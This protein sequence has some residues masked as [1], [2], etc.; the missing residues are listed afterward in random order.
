MSSTEKSP[1]SQIFSLTV[2]VASLGYFVDMFDLLLFPILR[3]PSLTDLGVP[4]GDAQVSAYF[5]LLNFQMVGMLLG[6]IFW[7]VLGDKKGRLST[8]FGSIALYSLANIANAFVHGIPA[9]AAWRFLAGLGLAGELGAAVTLVSEI[10][11]R[12]LRAY[13]TAIIAGVGIFG[14]VAASLVGKYLPWRVAYLVGG[15]LGLLLL[16]TRFSLRESAMF[17]DLGHRDG[18]ARGDFLSLFT[19]RER[20]FRYLR[21]ILIGLPTWFCVAILVSSAPEFAPRIGVTGPVAAG[22][23]VAF[24]YSGITIGSFASGILSQVWRSRKK[25]VLL[26]ILGTL[27]GVAAYLSLRGLTPMALYLLA[28]Y[29]GLATG[30]WAVFV[31]IAAEQFGTNLRSTVAT[32]VPNFV[33]GSVPLITGSFSFLAPRLGFIGS[34]WTVG[35]VCIGLALV[36]LGGMAETAGR[37]LDFL[38]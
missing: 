31:T 11:P 3:Q 20:F 32:T 19:S 12:N 33:R 35:L 5:L 17:R 22:T 25:V 6:G 15:G 9:Y 29:L 14:T 16:A 26:F 13:G 34:A 8:L 18:V 30:Y 1:L 37:D 7:G 10:L 27:A 36:S 2:L 24:C 28:G 38:E 21:C 4:P 23:A